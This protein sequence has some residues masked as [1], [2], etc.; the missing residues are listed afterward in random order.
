MSYLKQGRHA[1]LVVRGLVRAIVRIGYDEN[2]AGEIVECLLE[3]AEKD[4][5]DVRRFWKAL[6]IVAPIDKAV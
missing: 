1:K 3:D 4:G 2:S 5:L 6:E